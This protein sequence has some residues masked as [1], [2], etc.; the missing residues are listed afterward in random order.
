MRIKWF[1]DLTG[2]FATERPRT[3]I[4]IEGNKL[5][6][7]L[8]DEKQQVLKRYEVKFKHSNKLKKFWERYILGKIISYYEPGKVYWSTDLLRIRKN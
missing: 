4:K 7:A 1:K 3:V 5:K 8:L 2:L 6:C